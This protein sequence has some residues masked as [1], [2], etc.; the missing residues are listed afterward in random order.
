LLDITSLILHINERTEEFDFNILFKKMVDL[1]KKS[2]VPKWKFPAWTIL[3]KTLVV[4]DII[5]PDEV[6]S[7]IIL[8]LYKA[9][10]DKGFNNPDLNLFGNLK[11]TTE[12][13]NL[14]RLMVLDN[15]VKKISTAGEKLQEAHIKE[16]GNPFPLICPSLVDAIVRRSLAE[17][18]ENIPKFPWEK[19]PDVNSGCAVY[20]YM[21]ALSNQKYHSFV[22]E[23]FGSGILN[24]V[25][26]VDLNTNQ[27]FDLLNTLEKELS[28][29]LIS[30][31][32]KQVFG[33]KNSS[34]HKIRQRMSYSYSLLRNFSNEETVNQVFLKFNPEL[35]KFKELGSKFDSVLDISSYNKPEEVVVVLGTHSPDIKGA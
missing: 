5:Y 12:F 27:N 8:P 23:L 4:N 16:S 29:V 32:P 34:Y 26:L 10:R 30:V 11:V 13:R 15:L 14:L 3:F 22:A 7:C 9:L 2:G 6:L 33:K 28:K 25:D 1:K 35:E 19:I 24:D 21:L 17:N 20:H 31:V 18:K